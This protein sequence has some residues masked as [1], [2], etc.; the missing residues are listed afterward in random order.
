MTSSKTLLNKD[1][2]Y[3]DVIGSETLKECLGNYTSEEL[4][5]LKEE[6]WA[7]IELKRKISSKVMTEK[8]KLDSGLQP[9]S[10]TKVLYS[11]ILCFI[12][13]WKIQ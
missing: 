9:S 4:K 6:D 5:N 13:W 2:Q 7:I 3:C 11:I 1:Y 8:S 10:A 12:K